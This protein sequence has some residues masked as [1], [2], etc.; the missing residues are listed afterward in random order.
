MYITF[1]CSTSLTYVLVLIRI[2]FYTL[3]E[4]KL[5]G[6][7]QL[8]KGPNKNLLIGLPQPF[9]D[10][11]K[12]FT[13]E[14]T[15][16]KKI[17]NTPFILTPTI[18]LIIRLLL[19]SIY[20][21]HFPSIFISF[22][23]IYF[24]CVSRLNV[25]C[26]FIAGWCSNSKYALLG[27]LRRVAQTI[28]YEV[29]IFLILLRCL[30]LHHSININLININI[31]SWALL[32]LLPIFILWTITNLAETNRTPFD[33]VEGESELV[34]GFNIEYSRASFAIIFI[35]EYINI[36]I[37]CVLTTTFFLGTP[38]TINT[39]LLILLTLINSIIFVWVRASMPRIRYDKLIY[40]TW[41]C[42]LPLTLCTLL[43]LQTI[44]SNI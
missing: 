15:K 3:L 32:I 24:M 39:S 29:S 44:L 28:S 5:L 30:R 21:H 11:I 33:L 8:R 25:Y 35:A 26:T 22:G 7:Y 37:M 4:R 38:K 27:S 14:Q 19:W 40:L 20:P 42:F 16:S 36:L 23:V 13:N 2:A 43:T 41:K 18:T 17:N 12:L 34:S 9:A 1:I 31:K 6:Y 10:A